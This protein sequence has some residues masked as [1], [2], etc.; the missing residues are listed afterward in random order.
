MTLLIFGLIALL[1]GGTTALALL[2][3]K[4]V[5]EEKE[6][7]YTG[8]IVGTVV[9]F[10]SGCIDRPASEYVRYVVD[11]QTYECREAVKLKCEP[12]KPAPYP[13]ASART[14]RS[15]RTWAAGCGWRTC[16]ATR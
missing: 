3:A 11:G 8:E 14:P 2:I 13:W 15:P 10:S 6:R 4:R 1:G 16:R 12:I 9:R 5:R 7:E